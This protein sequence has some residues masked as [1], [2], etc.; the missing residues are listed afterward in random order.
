M[1][2]VTIIK[3]LYPVSIRYKNTYEQSDYHYTVLS[4]EHTTRKITSKVPII[5]D[6]QLVYKNDYQQS[7][8]H[9]HFHPVSTLYKKYY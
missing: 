4:C 6:C 9:L 2:K 1:N 8:H 3:H 7:D 5:K